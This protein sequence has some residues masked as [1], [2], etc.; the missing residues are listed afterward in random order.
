ML[1][2]ELERLRLQLQET[3]A[4]RGQEVS[5]PLSS[6]QEQGSLQIRVS[7][8]VWGGLCLSCCCQFWHWAAMGGKKV[9]MS[10]EEEEYGWK[11]SFPT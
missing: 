5:V 9:V 1:R 3:R 2:R 6:Q 8:G 7:M 4:E 10:G 11:E